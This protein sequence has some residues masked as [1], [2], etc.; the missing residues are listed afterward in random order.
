MTHYNALLWVYLE[1]EYKFSPT[2]FLAQMESKGI[3]PNR[4]SIY[5]T[6]YLDKGAK[7]TVPSGIW[8]Y[9]FPVI[10]LWG[11]LENKYK[12]SP[13]EFLAQMESKGI[14][15]NRV[16]IYETWCL[17]K[18]TKH[19]VPSG[20]WTYNLPVIK[21]WGYLENKYKFSPTEFLAQMESKG[22]EPNRVSIYETWCLDK[23]TK[24][25]VPCG[26]WTYNFPIG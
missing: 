10:K 23:G 26:V 2:E 21:L 22:I 3:E 1:N 15:P 11:Y 25:T 12:F 14:E 6:W 19:T 17:D 13:T 18:G 8:T 7:H 5:E 16:S 4:V 9:N 24:H 20:I